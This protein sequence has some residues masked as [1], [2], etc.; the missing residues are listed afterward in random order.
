MRLRPRIWRLRV[1]WWGHLGVAVVFGL[2]S[3]GLAA[4]VAVILVIDRL[5]VPACEAVT[6]TAPDHEVA[7]FAFDPEARARTFVQ[8]MAS[9]EFQTAYTIVALEEVASA[10]LC[11]LNLERFWRTVADGHDTLLSVE[12]FSPLVYSAVYDYLSVRLRLTLSV[13]GESDQPKREAY[14]EVLLTPDGRIA[15]HGHFSVLT[16][17]GPPPESPS[18]PYV[19]PDSFEETQVTV[20]Q[21]PWELGGTL[22]M[23]RGVGPFAAVVIL[24]ASSGRDGMEGANKRDRDLAQGLAARGVAA[25]RY[26]DRPWAHGLAAARQ[27]DFTM[28]DESENDALAA[29]A[30]LRQTPRIDPEK[31]YVLGIGYASFAS[32]RVAHLDAGLAGMILISPSAGLTWDWAWRTHQEHAEVDEDVTEHE[33]R[34]IEALKARAAT[35]AAIAAGTASPHDLGVRVDYHINLVNYRPERA[36]RTLRIP[37]LALFGDHDGVVPIDD[38]EAWIVSL[39][40][41]PDA[42][43]RVYEGHSHG[44]F[45]VDTMSGPKRRLEGHVDE[46]VSTDIAAWIDG[47]WPQRSCRDGDAWYAGCHGG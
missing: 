13:D 26:D 9:N 28:F 25:L 18:P 29:L 45:D 27:S 46:E 30:L 8:A 5:A 17:L 35:I 14:I 7:P 34:V 2:F 41:R 15:S 11:E 16:E 37:I 19:D 38:H 4:L 31:I 3:S 23:P 40:G 36:V 21:A 12:R 24:G 39:L 22:A 32:S 42:A 44:M 1:A 43:I 20:G 47:D 33:A 6:P 10:S